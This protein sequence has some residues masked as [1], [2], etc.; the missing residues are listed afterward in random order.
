MIIESHSWGGLNFVD[1][2]FDLEFFGGGKGG[3]CQWFYLC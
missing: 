2:S 3:L 1:G